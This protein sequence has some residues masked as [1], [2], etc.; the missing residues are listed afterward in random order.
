VPIDQSGAAQFLTAKNII[1]LHDDLLASWYASPPAAVQ[2]GESLA[3]IVPAQHFCN[4]S[5]WNHEDQA[6]RRDVSD[7]VIAKTKRAIDQWNQKRNDLME[8]VDLAVLDEMV[9]AN[10]SNAALHSETAGMMVDRLS[11]LSLKI[12]HMGQYAQ[13]IA[14]PG[15]AQECRDKQVRLNVQRADLAGCLETLMGEFSAGTRHF[16]LYRQFKAYNDPR[17]NP[18]LRNAGA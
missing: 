2:P 6:R 18:A 4:F 7:S 3:T 1:Q 16:K 14:D 13:T 10:V 11:I 9:G 15:V 5:L 17:L 8:R 12:L